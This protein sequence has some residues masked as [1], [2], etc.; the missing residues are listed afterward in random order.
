[1]AWTTLRIRNKVKAILADLEIVEPPVHPELVAKSLG[2][3]ILSKTTDD[4]LSGFLY[5]DLESNNV[6]IGVNQ[7]HHPNRRRFTIAH[8]IGHFLLHEFDGGFHFDSSNQKYLLK[9]RSKNSHLFN[10]IEER[11][12][13]EFAAELLMPKSLIDED[14]DDFTDV[15]LMYDDDLA[16]LAQKYRVSTQALT[17]RLMNLGHLDG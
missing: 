15:D 17:F 10:K 6:V 14:M 5:K 7:S 12:A 3:K 13:N 16:E 8:E 4:D 11:E 9:L 1:M 2:I